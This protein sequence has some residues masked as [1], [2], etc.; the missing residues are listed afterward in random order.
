MTLSGKWQI[1]QADYV[2]ISKQILNHILLWKNRN[3][4]LMPHG[5]LSGKEKKLK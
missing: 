3:S 5:L 2:T 4:A 1:V